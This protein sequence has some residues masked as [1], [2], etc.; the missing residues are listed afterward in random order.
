MEEVI[1]LLQSRTLEPHEDTHQFINILKHFGSERAKSVY[2]YL[3]ASGI[4]VYD[5]LNPRMD[6]MKYDVAVAIN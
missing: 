3:R 2:S 1:D 5:T 4:Y 6:R